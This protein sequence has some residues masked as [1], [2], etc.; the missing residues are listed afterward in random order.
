MAA[1]SDASDTTCRTVIV[2]EGGGQIRYVANHGR[3]QVIQLRPGGRGQLTT[4]V[5]D[6][7]EAER[8]GRRILE[9]VQIARAQRLQR[10]TT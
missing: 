5:D 9:V 2:T 8:H 3:M 1:L 4:N 6:L 10:E 7:D